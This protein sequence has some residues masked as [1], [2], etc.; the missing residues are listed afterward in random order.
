ML[1]SSTAA[2]ADA[3]TSDEMQLQLQQRGG[4]RRFGW[5]GGC[6]RRHAVLCCE[7]AARGGNA[8]S[9]ERPQRVAGE[10]AGVGADTT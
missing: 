3:E 7:T 2:A 9:S 10:R 5:G 8:G 1:W 4:I 6:A